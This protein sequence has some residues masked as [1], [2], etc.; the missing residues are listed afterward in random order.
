MTKMKKKKNDIFR[1]FAAKVSQLA[2][3]AWAFIIALTIIITWAVVGPMFHFSN[4]WQLFINTFTTIVTLLM[5]F[6]IQNTQNR[7]AKAV[8]IKL[9]E[10]L[11]KLK[12]KSS[13]RYVAIEEL[14]DEEIEKLN[15]KFAKL[16]EK[17]ELELS[18]RRRKRKKG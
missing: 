11:L 17:Y 16:R 14:P 15:Q 4:T 7:D 6:I 12:G 10:L 5:V 18:E 2:G 3:T 13:D 9:D 1:T 8:H